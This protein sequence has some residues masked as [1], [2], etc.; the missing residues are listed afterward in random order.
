MD[1]IERLE[2]VLEVIYLI[3][4]EGYTATAGDHWMRPS[5]CDDALRLGRACRR[6]LMPHESEVHGLVTLMELQASRAG[7]RTS[8][9]GD[10]VRLLDQDRARWDWLQ[11]QRGLDA[12]GACALDDSRTRPL[13]DT[14]RTRRLP[15]A[16]TT[17]G[18]HRLA[19]RISR[20]YGE[21]ARISPSPFVELNR[22]VAVA[23]ADGPAAGLAIIDRITAEPSL[24]TYHLLPSV[25]G[26]LLEKFPGVATK[27]HW[28]LSAQPRSHRNTRE[29]ALLVERANHAR[30][31]ER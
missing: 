3:F 1:R 13:R 18:G 12:P 27:P 14:G 28:S 25:R 23:M 20:M 16:R 24:S 4:N 2:A 11:I 5:L 17:G 15:C 9:T 6:G 8:A 30:T 31:P 19:T 29:H 26:D 10:P 21:L 22:G 7:A